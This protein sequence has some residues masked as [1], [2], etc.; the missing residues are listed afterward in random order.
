VLPAII[1]PPAGP[2]ASAIGKL[3]GLMTANTPYGRSTD[4]VRSA[5]DS[6][7]IGFTKP[8]AFSNSSA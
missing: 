5:A 8:S 7:P 3:N 1:A 4:R 6:E 2:P